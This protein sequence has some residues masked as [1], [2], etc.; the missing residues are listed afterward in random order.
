MKTGKFLANYIKHLVYLHQKQHLDLH[1]G[2]FTENKIKLYNK[3]HEI[4][5]LKTK[6]GMT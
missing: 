1:V 5:R 2:K 6:S 4:Q 3:V